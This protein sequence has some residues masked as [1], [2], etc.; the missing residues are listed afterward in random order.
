V[1]LS[2]TGS[3]HLA[4]GRVNLAHRQVISTATCAQEVVAA[5]AATLLITGKELQ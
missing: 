5:L 2:T 4:P 3:L 1:T